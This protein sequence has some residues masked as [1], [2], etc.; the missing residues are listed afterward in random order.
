MKPAASEC[1]GTCELLDVPVAAAGVFDSGAADAAPLPAGSVP[2]T[3]G[4]PGADGVLGADGA[5]GRAGVP[6]AD[7]GD[8]WPHPPA[9]AA[10]PKATANRIQ[11]R[12]HRRR[13]KAPVFKHRHL[14]RGNGRTRLRR[15]FACRLSSRRYGGSL[16]FFNRHRGA[17]ADFSHGTRLAARHDHGVARCRPQ[18]MRPAR[19]RN[20]KARSTPRLGS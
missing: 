18:A 7:G 1:V 10:T 17:R 5:L 8:A 14:N 3:L 2:G 20:A 6:G 12:K 16:P 9:L 19:T 15:V 4:A 13:H 11:F